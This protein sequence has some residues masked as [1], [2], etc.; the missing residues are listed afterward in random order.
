M[1]PPTQGVI[2][3]VDDQEVNRYTT[4]RLLRDAGY[5]ILEAQNGQ[6]ALLL[7]S[8][9]L[10]DLI[11]LDVN[12]PDMDGFQVC[13]I[14]RSKVRTAQI[15]I[16]HASATFVSDRDR[17][18]GLNEG[19]DGYLIRPFEPCV[20]LATVRSCIR[21]RRAEDRLRQQARELQTLADNTPEFLLRFDSEFR[22]QFA[23]AAMEKATGLALSEILGKTHRDLGF[24]ESL[25]VFWEQTLRGVFESKSTQTVTFGMKS[26]TGD[27]Q[28]SARLVPE[29]DSEAKV[30]SVLA[31]IDDITERVSAEIAIKQSEL[32]FRTMANSISQLAWMAD[33]NGHIFWYNDRWLT[34][35]GCSLDELL[36]SGWESRLDPEARMQIIDSTKAGFAAGQPWE[37]TFQLLGCDGSYRWYLSRV[38]PAYDDSNAIALW[39]GTNT[40]IEELRRTEMERQKFV[41]LVE[42]SSDFIGI[43]DLKG[44]A[45][46]INRAGLNLIGIDDLSQ[47]RQIPVTDFF[48]N[49]LPTELHQRFK[50]LRKNGNVKF[51]AEVRDFK[52]GDSRWMNCYVFVIRNENGQ[53]IA[54]ST[55]C[56][57]TTERKHLEDTLRAV[58][59]DLSSAYR[60]QNEFLATLAHELRNPLAPIRTG[61]EIIRTSMDNRKVVEEVRGMMERQTIQMVRL[62]DDLL[63]L[64]RIQQDK[65]N[66]RIARIDLAEVLRNAI[67]SIRPFID[68]AK[69]TLEISLPPEPTFLDADSSRLAQ[70]FSNLL[71]N[72]AKYTPNGG[73]IR[74]RGEV[75]QHEV[76]VSVK[77]NGL[78][79]PL[80]MQ[81]R[82]FE[83]FTQIDRSVESHYT[84]LGVGLTLVQKIVKMH[85]GNVSVHSEGPNKG[86]EFTVCLP[87]VDRLGISEG[88]AAMEGNENVQTRR[89][90]V[91]DDNRD[92]ATSLGLVLN[93]MGHEVRT[94]YDGQEAVA[95][96]EAFRPEIILMDI[97]MPRMNGIEAAR[98]IRG[99]PWGRAVT[100]VALTGWG[101][102]SDK[103]RTRESGFD[104]HLTKPVEPEMIQRILHRL[105]RHVMP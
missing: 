101:Q 49:E 59:A 3:V 105:N 25:C 57:D 85:G 48:P 47:A 68:V 78:G 55:I 77:D 69:H 14:L 63:D 7:A 35:T 46:F 98:H 58:A 71:S 12:L 66:L 24:P 23:N 91:V 19:A 88:D 26:T 90:L 82:V 100:L 54:Y 60:R 83:M 44:M 67:E 45:I 43:Y 103:S 30:K 22:H 16:V 31:I 56:R 8:E 39:F 72:A 79:I 65:F 62:V 92:A 40:D 50:S 38:Q 73:V 1:N 21:A 33:A 81:D 13:R 87:I 76:R 34:Y 6:E 70:V 86:S 17:A 53:P 61:L 41:S 64:S 75:L 32:R 94:A 93:I 11:V 84:G 51:E 4:G 96:A 74:V 42:N 5:S 104:L 99:K 97:G 18:Q 80:E 28:Y 15:P 37:N 102:E 9:K 2:L 20:M 29:F 36:A 52:S 95:T 10:P 27:R 89:I